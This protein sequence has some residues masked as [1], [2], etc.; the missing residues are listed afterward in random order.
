MI[1]RITAAGWAAKAQ[2]TDARMPGGRL[3]LFERNGVRIAYF[4]HREMKQ[5]IVSAPVDGAFRAD[6]LLTPLTA[7]LGKVPKADPPGMRYLYALPRLDI[8]TVQIKAAGG[9]RSVE[10]SV[11]H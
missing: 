9:G 3:S 10:L 1:E 8:L 6:D 2:A 4:H 7:A 11:V 5:C